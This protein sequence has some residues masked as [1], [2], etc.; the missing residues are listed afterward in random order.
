[1]VAGRPRP[2]VLCRRPARRGRACDECRRRVNEAP[3]P[4]YHYCRDRSL[5]CVSVAPLREAFERSGDSYAEV[6]DRVGMSPERVREVLL[7]DTSHEPTVLALA[8]GL[9]VAPVELGL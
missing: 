8:R 3:A 6:A 9:H 1:M 2:C 5:G 4:A 7:C